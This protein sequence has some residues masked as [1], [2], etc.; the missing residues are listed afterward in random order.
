M[1]DKIS[2]KQ[3]ERA[4]YVYIR[5][6]TLQQVRHNLESNRRQYALRDRAHELGFR[7][8]VVIDDDLGISGTGHYERPGFGR[9]L[10]AVCNGQV[11]AV[12]ALEA[13]RLA[14]NNRDWHHLIDLCV[15]TETIVVDA[16]GVYDPR[17]LNDRLL[18]GL[19]G[20]MSEFELGILRQRAQEAYRQK[21]LRGEVL[22]RVSTGYVRSGASGI[23]MTPDREV[24]EAIRSLFFHFERLG[25][26]RQVLLWYHQEN[27]LF[28]LLRIRDGTNT[29]VWQL[30]HYEHLLRILKNPYLRGCLCLRAD[31]IPLPSG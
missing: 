10:A 2:T 1:S 15:L 13:S 11:G 28:P 22:T 16:E 24:Q 26:L 25:S 7:E 31:A 23:E 8:V 27:V 12:F 30:P 20:T 5:Q 6:S 14:R 3:L 9:L 21:V 4:A 29:L 18:L 17:L 19:K